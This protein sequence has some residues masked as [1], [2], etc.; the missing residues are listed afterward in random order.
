LRK[1]NVD[2]QQKHAINNADK[3]QDREVTGDKQVVM[4]DTLPREQP[5]V[6]SESKKA[7]ATDD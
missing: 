5:L 1:E 3:Q 7:N 2:A 4:E 6:E